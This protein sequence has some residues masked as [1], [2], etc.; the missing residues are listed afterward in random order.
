MENENMINILL[1]DDRPENLLAL[2]AIIES[3]EY[4]LIKANS[5]E[6]ALKYLLK[7]DFAAILL[8]V[9]MPGMDG[10]RTAKI[11]KA[12]E[13]TKHIPILFITANHMESEH[14]FM[15][16]SV[17]AID[18][19]LKPIDPFVLKSKVDGF[20]D[21]YRLHVQ[22]VQQTKAL[23]EKNNELIEKN[24][25]LV[26]L[27]SELRKSEAIANIIQHTSLDAMI[28]L[29][30][31]GTILQTNPA[32]KDILLYDVD[33]LLD[34]SITILLQ[35]VDMASVRRDIY[36]TRSNIRKSG[37]AYRRDGQSIHAEIHF[38]R[39]LVN[40]QLILACTIRDISERKKHE[41]MTRFMAYHDAL[42]ELPN[43]TYFNEKLA[44]EIQEAKFSNQ[45]FGLMYLDL[46]R[47]K[48]IN[49][50]LGHLIGDRLLIEVSRRLLEV[51]RENDVVAR[52]GGDEFNILLPDS[53]REE[54]LQIAENILHAFKQPFYI[55]QYELFISTCIGLSVFPY[56]GDGPV[57]IIKNADIALNRAKKLGSDQYQFYHAGLNI[58]SYRN[59]TMQNDLRKALSR[60]ELEINYQPKVNLETGTIAGFD[61]LLQWNHPNWGT[62]SVK[63]LIPMLEETGVIVD[64][65]LWYFRKV[66]EQ[67]TQWKIQGYPSVRTGVFYS[68]QQFLHKDL[69]STI[70][71]IILETK[72]DPTLIEIGIL[73][74]MIQEY[75]VV[76]KKVLDQLNQIGF[77]IIIYNFGSGHLSVRYVS[78]FPIKG[79]SMEKSFAD[80]LTSTNREASLFITTIKSFINVLQIE[81]IAT[82][83]ED[84]EQLVRLKELGCCIVSG[85][86]VHGGFDYSQPE[87]ILS[88]KPFTINLDSLDNKMTRTNNIEAP[89]INGKENVSLQEAM[90]QLQT[91]YNIT[92]R[93]MD[94]FELILKG[95]SNKEIAESLYISEHTVKNHVTRIF[96]KMGVNDRVHAI[97]ILY[98]TFRSEHIKGA[99]E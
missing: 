10:I 17:G 20:I 84:A 74:C 99:L 3:E 47:F 67:I 91:K 61:A 50:S 63:E 4:N 16:Y 79:I 36:D 45:T 42:T 54:A 18:Y 90:I 85:P 51:V 46:D 5:G 11:I 49:D 96:N 66:C 93:E 41:E 57:E 34:K 25:E 73:E 95:S 33:E 94:V 31:Q 7:Y 62:V 1:V 58:Q 27:A 44:S 77:R 68:N 12:R 70:Q 9:Q 76:I 69:F 56:D 89:A 24:K 14:I 52:I 72:V 64:V 6:E 88:G 43:V 92:S 53:S 32:V 37:V 13:K 19:I 97:T 83:V 22:L 23:E 39:Q 30:E 60:N 98:Q 81:V 29:D 55:D 75:E 86:A 82:D 40:N 78:Q 8:D 35:D 48:F 26:K 38:G 15:G 59:F 2:E 80:R 65:W 21:I 87:E 71:Q 28:L